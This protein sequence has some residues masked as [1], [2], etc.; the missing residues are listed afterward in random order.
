MSSARVDTFIDAMNDM[1]WRECGTPPTHPE[2]HYFLACHKSP[3]DQPATMEQ[4]RLD[5]WL[6]WLLPEPLEFYRARALAAR[7][8]SGLAERLTTSTLFKFS[9]GACK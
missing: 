4:V 5:L 8:Q 1:S 2:F 3:P 9:V 6:T 7:K